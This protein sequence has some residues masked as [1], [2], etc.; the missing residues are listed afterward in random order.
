MNRN[1]SVLGSFRPHHVLCLGTSL[2]I[3][4]TL[5]QTEARLSWPSPWVAQEWS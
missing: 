4:N 5:G 3:P 1:M 2:N